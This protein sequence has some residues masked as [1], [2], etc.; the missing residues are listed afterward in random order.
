M[1]A[2]IRLGCVC[3]V[4]RHLVRH[5]IGRETEAFDLE[6]LEMRSLAQ[7]SYLEPGNKAGQKDDGCCWAGSPFCSDAGLCSTFPGSIKH[8]YLYHNSQSKKALFGLFIPSQRKASV[9]VVDTVRSQRQG[10]GGSCSQLFF[11]PRM[12][13]TLKFVGFPGKALTVIRANIH[14]LSRAELWGGGNASVSFAEDAAWLPSPDITTK[15][16]SSAVFLPQ[17]PGVILTC[18]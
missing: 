18:F 1:R 2:L 9:F 5:L 10:W 14:F 15:P 6:H 17:I 13:T 7:F 12:M 8:I 4:N 11:E 16:F 3:I